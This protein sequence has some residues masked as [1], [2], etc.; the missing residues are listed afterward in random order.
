MSMICWIKF[1]DKAAIYCLNV[2]D[3][4]QAFMITKFS[5]FSQ[6]KYWMLTRICLAQPACSA[7]P[8]GSVPLSLGILPGLRAHSASSLGLIMKESASTWLL[9]PGQPC[10]ARVPCES[11]ALGCWAVLVLNPPFWLFDL[12]PRWLSTGNAK[13]SQSSSLPFETLSVK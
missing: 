5:F 2:G 11:W 7:L 3:R 6:W 8:W 1:Y 13:V 12:F 4:R 9:G 10:M